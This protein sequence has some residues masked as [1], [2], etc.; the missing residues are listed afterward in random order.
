MINIMDKYKE[1]IK[2]YNCRDI[3]NLI[4]EYAQYE[5]I[6]ILDSYGYKL[7]GKEEGKWIAWYENGNKLKEGEYKNGLKEE[8]WITWWENGKKQDEGEYKN[9][10]RE[11]NWI[12]WWE[13][14]NKY[15]EGGY[16]NGVSE[17]KWITW[18]ENRNKR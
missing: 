1:E 6:C 11:G 17:G 16:K 14:G 2:K 12:T 3:T 7:F 9:E 4:L 15:N 10:L 8:K 5:K 18:W 13:S